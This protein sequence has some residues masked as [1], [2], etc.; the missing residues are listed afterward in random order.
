M[1]LRCGG[2]E[3]LKGCGIEVFRLEGLKELLISCRDEEMRG[4]GFPVQ[5]LRS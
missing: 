1:W 3:G 2:V 5:E 4:K